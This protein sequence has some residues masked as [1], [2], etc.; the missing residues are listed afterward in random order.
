MSGK[1]AVMSYGVEQIGGYS[2]LPPPTGE[3]GVVSELARTI[4]GDQGETIGCYM[5]FC[6]G[7]CGLQRP[8]KR[9]FIICADP[10][11]PSVVYPFFR[12]TKGNI[13]VLPETRETAMARAGSGLVMIDGDD[14]LHDGYPETFC[15]AKVLA[16]GPDVKGLFGGE[17]VL[18]PTLRD[19]HKYA[20]QTVLGR[21]LVLWEDDIYAVI[22][23]EP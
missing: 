15:F 9:A 2:H 3:R 16:V 20:F 7:A 12:P 1:G 18:I 22:E 10:A 5:D 6:E 4:S 21:V 14:E 17:K 19:A 8:I 11:D 23:D 13:A